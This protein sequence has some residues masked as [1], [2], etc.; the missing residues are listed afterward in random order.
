MA[1]TFKEAGAAG[2]TKVVLVDRDLSRAAAL[3]AAYG[4]SLNPTLTEARDLG[5]AMAVTSTSSA[6]RRP[7]PA[8]SLAV[9]LYHEAYASIFIVS[10]RTA[11][12]S[13]GISPLRGGRDA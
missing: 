10:A 1:A 9:P 13:C 12:L 3:G 11:D 2:P 6:T 4:G 8:P 5:A 7:C